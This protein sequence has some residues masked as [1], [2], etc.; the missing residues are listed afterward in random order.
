MSPK[1][2]AALPLCLAFLSLSPSAAAQA[3][4]ASP[5]PPQQPPAKKQADPALLRQAFKSLEEEL[6]AALA[7]YSAAMEQARKQGLPEEAHPKVPTKDFFPRFEDLALQDQPDA[8]RWCIGTV[9]MLE[10]PMDA[11]N[12]RKLAFYERIVRVHPNSPWMK[13]IVRFMEDEGLPMGIPLESIIPLLDFVVANCSTPTVQAQALMTKARL[14]KKSKDPESKPLMVQAL[15]E[16]VAKYPLTEDGKRAKALLF[17]LEELAV[18]KTAP[19]FTTKDVD[20]VEFKL[21][22]YL[23][24]VV[25]LDFWGF[26]C[27]TCERNIPH[28]REMVARY[29]KEPFAMIGIN[30]DSNKEAFKKKCEELGVNWR[31]SWQGGRDGPLVTE[32]GLTNYPVLLV[33]DAKGVIRYRDIRG[34]SLT[35][36]VET[37]LAEIK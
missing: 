32:W 18:G 25:V 31:N 6:T 1:T 21:S 12:A 36:A 28:E 22:D 19:D 2:S 11:T 34:D 29:S 26:W 8:L 30:T 23:G 10:L 16:V 17:Q 9:N 5:A 37:L 15:K 7:E 3:Q 33:L 4:A 24:Q 13:D 35:Q 27:G 14:Y 20:G